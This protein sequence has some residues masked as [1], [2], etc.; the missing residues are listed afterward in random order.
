MKVSVKADVDSAVRG[1][2][3][4][5]LLQNAVDV[6][7]LEE[8]SEVSWCRLV[9]PPHQA[10][11]RY[12][13]ATGRGCWQPWVLCSSSTQVYSLLALDKPALR[14]AGAEFVQ[15]CQC[16][17]A[18]RQD[19]SMKESL[20]FLAASIELNY[21][22]V[23]LPLGH[24]VT[25]QARWLPCL[26]NQ[27]PLNYFLLWV[28]RDPGENIQYCKAHRQGRRMMELNLTDS[29]RVS[30]VDNTHNPQCVQFFKVS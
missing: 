13:S 3:N 14:H 17:Y 12:K 2:S 11:V 6:E 24:R 19:L 8:E 20:K 16:G 15:Q 7:Q 4:L 22:T 28:H 23:D 25:F 18:S 27:I 21:L 30:G 29:S 10:N 9:K 26:L 5:R 1:N